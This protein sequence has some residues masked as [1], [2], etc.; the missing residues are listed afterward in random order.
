M[1][2]SI[3]NAPTYG[4]DSYDADLKHKEQETPLRT[5]QAAHPQPHGV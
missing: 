5:E 4:L 3:T 1:T 2:A